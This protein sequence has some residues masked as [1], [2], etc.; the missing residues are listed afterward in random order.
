MYALNGIITFLV[1]LIIINSIIISLAACE[2]TSRY[3]HI[4]V[5][6]VGGGVVVQ[7]L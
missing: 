1:L 4:P 7:N 3:C 2:E 5:V 6:V